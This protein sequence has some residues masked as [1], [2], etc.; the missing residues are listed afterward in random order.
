MACAVRSGHDSY[1]LALHSFF[2]QLPSPIPCARQI[3]AMANISI[4]EAQ[5]SDL[6]ALTAIRLSSVRND[7]GSPY[8]YPYAQ[9]FPDDHYHY[10]RVQF[11]EYLANVDVG[12]YAVM[13]AECPSNENPAIKEA[14]AMSVWM[15]PGTHGADPNGPTD[16]QKG[17]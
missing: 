12:A 9:Q 3:V 13:L 17:S 1:I 2:P 4:R 8:R 6:D 16:V 15:L 10:T 14:V 7:P 5:P 11:S